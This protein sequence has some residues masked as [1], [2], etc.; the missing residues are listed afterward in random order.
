MSVISDLYKYFELNYFL[1]S[2]H[3]IGVLG[4]GYVVSSHHRKFIILLNSYFLKLKSKKKC[5]KMYIGD[6]FFFKNI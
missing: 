6:E 4:K 2:F 1:L 3:T 5:K